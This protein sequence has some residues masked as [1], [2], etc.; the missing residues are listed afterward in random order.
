MLDK[1]EIGSGEYPTPGYLHQDITPNSNLD[2]VCNPWEIPLKPDSVSDVIALGVIEHLR[3]EEFNKTLQYISSILRKDGL[4]SFDVPDMVVWS[5]YLYNTTHNQSNLNP[6]PDDHVWKSIYGWQ[7][8]VGDEHKSGWTREILLKEIQKV[9]VFVIDE[10]GPQIFT[11]R[12]IFRSRFNNPKDA[13]IYLSL[14]R[15]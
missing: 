12:K 5:E 13:H 3:F 6:F 1:L 10:E 8:W 14:K 9:S 11:K 7:R 15:R 4:F 2:F